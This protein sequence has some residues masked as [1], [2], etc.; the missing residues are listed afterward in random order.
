MKTSLQEIDFTL[1]PPFP[2]YIVKSD[3]M[4]QAC[5]YL[6]IESRR[7]L[8]VFYI[9]Q[10]VTARKI[11]ALCFWIFV[12]IVKGENCNQATAIKKN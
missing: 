12:I 8:R 1:M 2:M 7:L 6:K 5:Y 3:F 11:F 4:K 10:T 9:S